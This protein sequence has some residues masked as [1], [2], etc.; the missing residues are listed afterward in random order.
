MMEKVTP[1]E[2]Y[3]D[4]KLKAFLIGSKGEEVYTRRYKDAIRALEDGECVRLSVH[5]KG[6][7]DWI[8]GKVRSIEKR[9]VHTSRHTYVMRGREKPRAVE[10][11]LFYVKDGKKNLSLSSSDDKL[12]ILHLL[13]L[14]VPM[15]ADVTC[16]DGHSYV[17]SRIMDF[18]LVKRQFITERYSVYRW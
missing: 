16:R 9:Q 12:R 13:N 17:T 2:V 4:C 15:Y 5:V 1:K 18:D 7:G 14:K 11:A 10:S 8:T 3:E 6:E